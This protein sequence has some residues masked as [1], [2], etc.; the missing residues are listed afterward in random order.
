M[1]DAKDILVTTGKAVVS[2]IPVIGPF[3][4]EFIGLAQENV[5]NKRQEE[6]MTLVNAKLTVLQKR[7]DELSNSEFFVSVVQKATTYAMQSHEAK[8][9]ELFSN[10]IYNAANVDISEDKQMRYIALLDQYTMLGIKL[11]EF[12]SSNHY[13]EED[14]V[15]HGGMVTTYTSPGGE[16]FLSFLEDADE[17]FSDSDYIRNICNQLMRDGLIN[18]ID[19]R[20]PK[21]PQQIRAKH[22]TALGDEFLA[23]ILK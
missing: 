11:L 22:T 21:H 23:Y 20:I 16:F 2:T 17:D 19:F 6:W 8:K 4:A 10:I 14:Y 5:I 15:H 13:R 7:M 1:S 9:R 3:A 18:D 12:L